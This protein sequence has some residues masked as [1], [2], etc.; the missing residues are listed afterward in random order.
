M[1]ETTEPGRILH[2]AA[3]DSSTRFEALAD[4][5]VERVANSADARARLGQSTFDCLVVEGDDSASL[6]TVRAAPDSLPVLVLSATPSGT[7]ADGTA[8]DVDYVRTDPS[9]PDVASLAARVGGAVGRRQAARQA[10]SAERACR[11]VE[12]VGRAVAAAETRAAVERRVCDTVAD[13]GPYDAVGIDDYDADRGVVTR[14]A[15][16]GDAPGDPEEEMSATGAAERALRTGD[17]TV[18]CDGESAWSDDRAA[19]AVPLCDDG[20]MVGVLHV[21]TDRTDAFDERV[22]EALTAVGTVVA[23]AVTRAE[24]RSQCARRHRQF[25]SAVE[26]AGHVVLLTD[27]DGR[28]TY[29]NDAFESVTGYTEAEALGHSPALLQSGTHD[30]TFYRDLWETISSGETWEGEVVNERKDGTEYII[31]QTIAP[32]SDDDGIVGYIA[33]NRDITER[34]E[35]ELNLAFLK[36]AIDQAGIGIGTY[37]SDGYATYV[38][39]R[40]AEQ[41]GTSRDDL[42]ERHMCS[43]DPT[44][45]KSRFPSY[46]SSFEDGERRIRDARIER[47]DTGECVP[48]EVVSSRVRI[49][50]DPYQV[51]TLRDATERKRQERDLERF[52]SAVDHAGHS[53]LITD[54]EGR[55]EY[56]NDAF[57]STTG[58]SAAEAIGQTPA[59][60][61]SDEHDETFYDDLWETILDGDVWQGEVVNERKDGEQYVVD[62]T[63]APISD[64]DSDGDGGITGF[65]A[66]NRDVSE[67]RAYER[68]LEAQNDRLKQYGETVAHDL[69]NPLAA[70]DADLKRFRAAIDCGESPAGDAPAD[71]VDAEAVRTL[72]TSIDDTVDRMEALIE[73]LLTMAEHGRR[74]IDAQPVSIAAVAAE[75]WEGIDTPDAELSVQ[76]I[77]VDADPDRVR[78]LLANLFRNSVEHGSTRNRTQSG[79]S[80][81]HG[82]T[83]SR[84]QSDDSVEHGSTDESGVHV[85]VSPLDFSPGFAV[86]DDGP[87]I[88]EDERDDVFER[89]FTTAADGTGFGLA[90][91]E[92]IA[93]AH[94]WSV[95]VTESRAGG[96]RFEFRTDAGA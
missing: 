43:L 64:G 75:A 94:G 69:R 42:R 54:A 77:T 24:T 12:S 18:T 27:A 67:L 49:D 51:N 41:F 40:L 47:L 3:G 80:V 20:A 46:W 38:N 95:S 78:E 57:E 87:G 60:L 63:I 89:G 52:R 25:R 37:G 62:Q 36:R 92:R 71:T 1:S 66:V 82:S 65:V 34:K 13:V 73:D 76:D 74:V 5:T 33:I 32:I 19:A 30:G 84:T 11:L 14:R 86:E 45:E 68:E 22:I 7:V 26:H 35:R 48:V 50:G 23:D 59:L 61:R 96:A 90:I 56:V 31:D 44:L 70:L 83:G 81:E 21:A 72:C 4:W 55:I 6:T 85:R 17:V 28:I 93:D 53:V 16:A 8:T 79:D 15:A 29:V 88:P 58:Y 9:D 10:A 91:V 2:V 39:E